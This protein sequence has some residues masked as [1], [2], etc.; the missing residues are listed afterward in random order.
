MVDNGFLSFYQIHV[1]KGKVVCNEFGYIGG[2]CICMYGQEIE[3]YRQGVVDCV[4][5]FLALS[6]LC[7]ARHAVTVHTSN[8][9]SRRKW[10]NQL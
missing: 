1:K 4:S 6:N 2:C 9:A 10:V 3:I 8:L 5:Q 7:K